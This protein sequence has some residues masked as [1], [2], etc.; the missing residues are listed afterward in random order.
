MIFSSK[1]SR[2]CIDFTIM[3][4]FFFALN[5]FWLVEL[6]LRSSYNV[7]KKK[8]LGLNGN[9]IEAYNEILIIF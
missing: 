5:H 4:I 6:L 1:S 3:F 7:L 9:F 8:V 2:E